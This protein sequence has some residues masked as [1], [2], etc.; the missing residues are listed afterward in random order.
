MRTLLKH[1]STRAKG[2]FGDFF[3][4]EELHVSFSI[5]TPRGTEMRIKRR[6]KKQRLHHC[7]L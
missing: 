2:D 1:L 4:G 6:E 5:V 7:F 3:P